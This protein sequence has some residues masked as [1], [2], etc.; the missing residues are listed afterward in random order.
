MTNYNNK[1][2]SPFYNRS[3]SFAACSL[4]LLI[5]G[6]RV[7][8]SLYRHCA[9]VECGIDVAREGECGIGVNWWRKLFRKQ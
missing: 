1:K 9:Y 6:R 8:Q 2:D 5:R 4:R 7:A 3:A